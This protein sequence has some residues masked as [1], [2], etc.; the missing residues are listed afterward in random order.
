[1]NDP[2]LLLESI[3]TK[4]ASK[5]RVFTLRN[6][7]MLLTVVIT[8]VSL[9]HAAL[10]KVPIRAT[11]CVPIDYGDRMRDVLDRKGIA[12]TRD[13]WCKFNC[14]YFR[15]LPGG[16]LSIW[17]SQTHLF[18]DAKKHGYY[19]KIEYTPALERYAWTR[20]FGNSRI[21]GLQ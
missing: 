10:T 5:F 17:M 7:L 13:R 20:E 1:M 6:Y 11:L 3:K 16:G 9:S 12:A 14:Q 8:V 21:V 15:S 4:Q 18:S 19:C 2:P